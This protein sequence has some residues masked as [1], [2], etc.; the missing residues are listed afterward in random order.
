[1]AHTYR[2]GRQAKGQGNRNGLKGQA[3]REGRILLWL[4]GGVLL[5]AGC[6]GRTPREKSSSQIPAATTQTASQGP[7]VTIGACPDQLIQGEGFTVQLEIPEG[8]TVDSITAQFTTQSEKLR[9]KGAALEIATSENTPVGRQPLSISAWREG[10]CRVCTQMVEVIPAKAPRK[11]GYRL[12]KRYPHAED[13]YTQGLLMHEGHLYEST[14]QR[15]ESTLRKVSITEGK[16]LAIRSLAPEYFAEGLALVKDRLYQLTWTSRKGF[17]YALSDFSPRDEFY[18]PTQGWGLT[19]KGDTL[20][21]SDGSSTLY[22]Y[23][24]PTFQPLGSRN[25]YREGE[26]L[27]MLNELEYVEGIVYANLYLSNTIVGIN[28]QTGA[29]VEELDLSALYPMGERTPK[30]DVLNGIAYDS[31]TQTLYVTGKY[32]PWLYQIELTGRR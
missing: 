25:V 3:M 7:R 9:V 27:Q 20:Y 6:Q 23:L 1:M 28:P 5:L 26:P 22:L 29:V 4:I 12:V 16:V 19:A 21:M 11:L 31:A 30:A 32:W 15:G 10:E 2:M 17:V 14:G 24:A 8:E 13:A 18:Y